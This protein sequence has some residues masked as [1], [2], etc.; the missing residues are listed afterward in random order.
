MAKH[1][2]SPPKVVAV[3]GDGY[4]GFRIELES[5]FVLEGFPCD[6]E[7]GEFSEH[8]R[9]FGHRSDDKHFVVTGEGVES[10]N[11]DKPN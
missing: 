9:L 3:N 2:A 6:S 10:S 11:S 8:W 5:S 4:G 1:Q 7:R